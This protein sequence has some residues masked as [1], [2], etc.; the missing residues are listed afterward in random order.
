MVRQRGRDYFTEPSSSCC[1]LIFSTT[2]IVSFE[3]CYTIPIMTSDLIGLP[4]ELRLHIYSWVIR[5][6][7]QLKASS[8]G[9]GSL[10]RASK[11]TRHELD[12][13]ILEYVKQS[14]TALFESIFPGRSVNC[15]HTVVRTPDDCQYLNI[16]LSIPTPRVGHLGNCHYVSYNLRSMRA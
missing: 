4:A 12:H 6:V 1:F 16:S 15:E 3:I 2:H 14:S 5:D 9:L 10:R 8:T 13:E 7:F 11:L